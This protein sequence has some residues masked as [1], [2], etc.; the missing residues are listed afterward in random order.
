MGRKVQGLYFLTGAGLVIKRN[1][2]IVCNSVLNV[3]NITKKN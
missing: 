2:N 1:V 3:F